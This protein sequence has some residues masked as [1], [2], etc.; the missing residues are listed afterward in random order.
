MRRDNLVGLALSAAATAAL[1]AGCSGSPQSGGALSP[2]SPNSQQQQSVSRA[3][4]GPDTDKGMTY[5]GTIGGTTVYGYRKPNRANDPPACT[6][7]PFV[8]VN[9]GIGVD[10]SGNLWVPDQGA[11]PKI[12]TEYGPNCGTAKTVLT[13]SGVYDGHVCPTTWR[14]A[15]DSCDTLPCCTPQGLAVD[16]RNNVWVS[17]RDPGSSGTYV[18]EF[19][20]GNMPA[21]LF[22]NISL[23]FPGSL[24]FDRNQNM[25]A[26]APGVPAMYVYAPPYTQS[27]PTTQL[28]MQNAPT[29]CTLGHFQTKLYCTNGFFSKVDIYTYPAGSYLYSY[30]NGLSGLIPFGIANDP[31]AHN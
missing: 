27:K 26:L 25:L 31:A 20:R 3:P 13:I 9:G 22:H 29:M 10:R 14:P 5:L 18:A 17:Y 30:T 12:V 15:L 23:G 28:P 16:N 1:L 8:S 24:Q 7:G 6:V 19:P 4:A 11:N 21:K 2:F